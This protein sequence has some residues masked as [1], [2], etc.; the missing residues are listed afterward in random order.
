MNTVNSKDIKSY[1]N[2]KR[3]IVKQKRERRVYSFPGI[4]VH[5]KYWVPNW[6]HSRVTRKG[7]EMGYYDDK[8]VPFFKNMITSN[9]LDL[10]YTIETGTVAGSS[11]D[12]WESL[13][14]KVGKQKLIDFF[15]LLLS[16]GLEKEAIFTDLA[17]S[18]IISKN[19]IPC[20]IDLEGL[21]SFSWMFEGKP[22]S[23]E[24]QNRNLAKCDNPFYRGF[25]E[26]YVKFVKDV[27]GIKDYDGKLNSV[28]AVESM[29]NLVKD[30]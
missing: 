15:K 14:N 9:G 13:I 5:M 20:L 30:K 16:R 24:A 19:G 4:N 1:D 8:T 29:Y 2:H 6:E 25:D 22:L 27:I 18:N 23:H 28:K 21:E 11:I 17:P 12:N 3:F 26:Y 7:F 10:G